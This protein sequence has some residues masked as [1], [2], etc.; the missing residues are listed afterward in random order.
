MISFGF[1]D[2]IGPGCEF[3]GKGLSRIGVEG[4]E[5]E[6]GESLDGLGVVDN[7]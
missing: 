6:F 2:G 7:L 5:F 4:S 3:S 1:F